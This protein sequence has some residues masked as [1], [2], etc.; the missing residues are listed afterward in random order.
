MGMQ[1]SSQS[2]REMEKNLEGTIR[3][4]EQ[5]A[6][7]IKKVLSATHGW[8]DQQSK[9]FRE[10]MA[11]IGKLTVQPVDQLKNTI[12]RMEKLAQ[13]VDEYSKIRF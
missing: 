8:E 9:E 4:L 3:D 6:T 1:A 7:G 13:S 11:K 10:V 2:I 5:I 12:P